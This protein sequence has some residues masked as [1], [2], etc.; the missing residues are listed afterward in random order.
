MSYEELP[1]DVVS[2]AIL[3]DDGS[4]DET[5]RIAR[6][7]ET[8]GVRSRPQLKGTAPIRKRVTPRH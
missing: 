1:K 4:T 5:L 6:E 3:V 8:G 7:T 2:T